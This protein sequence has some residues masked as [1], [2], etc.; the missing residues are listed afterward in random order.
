MKMKVVD[1]IASSHIKERASVLQSKTQKPLRFEILECTRA[2]VEK[3]MED[4]LM[5]GPEYFWPGLFR[6]STR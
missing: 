4:E 3:W 1:V 5:F 2:S 6:I